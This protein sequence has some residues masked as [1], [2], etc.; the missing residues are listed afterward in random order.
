MIAL[1]QGKW[2]QAGSR[3]KCVGNQLVVLKG[4]AGSQVTPL[5]VKTL[6]FIA[7]LERFQGLRVDTEA[8]TAGKDLRQ[9]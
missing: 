5:Q 6:M 8:K 1:L 9:N 4:V 2:H 3:V 7:K